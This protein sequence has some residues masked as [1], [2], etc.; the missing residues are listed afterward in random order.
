MLISS[1]LG[2]Q[3]DSDTTPVANRPAAGV[4][5]CVLAL[6][7]CQVPREPDRRRLDIRVEIIVMGRE[8]GLEPYRV[9]V[10]VML[11][12]AGQQRLIIAAPGLGIAL[13][14]VMVDGDE[15]VSH[16]SAFTSYLEV[17]QP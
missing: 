3:A 15:F 6:R 4:S 8:P 13:D 2:L 7:P 1:S 5:F 12:Q 16:I 14:D 10:V 11:P 17:V 9:G